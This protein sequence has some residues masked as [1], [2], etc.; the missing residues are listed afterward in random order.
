MRFVIE[1]INLLII[2]LTLFLTLT[3]A[4]SFPAQEQSPQENIF[5]W[6]VRSDNLEPIKLTAVK[7]GPSS[8]EVCDGQKKY[9][10]EIR[11][12]GIF[13]P[14]WQASLWFRSSDN[15]FCRY[16]SRHGLWGTPSTVIFLDRKGG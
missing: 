10:V 5:F 14:L 9:L 3:S 12:A 8:E 16:E 4:F 15:V 1:S 2:A 13:A 6:H 11:P 7:I